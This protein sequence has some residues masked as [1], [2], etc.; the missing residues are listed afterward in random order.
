MVLQA[1]K[2]VEWG[3]EGMKTKLLFRKNIQNN[4]LSDD[5][6]ET[7]FVEFCFLIKILV[8]KYT[9]R[10]TKTTTKKKKKED[11]KVK[12]KSKALQP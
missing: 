2:S 10:K 11:H 3:R 1:W 7:V 4:F 8:R 5:Y 6:H 9:Y 12:I